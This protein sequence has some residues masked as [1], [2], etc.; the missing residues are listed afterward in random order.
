MRR[1]RS[2]LRRSGRA[3]QSLAEFTMVVPVVIGLFV[4]LIEF[5]Q[6]WHSYQ[7]VTHAARE[8]VRMSIVPGSDPEEVREAVR[9]ILV[10]S[11]LKAEHAEIIVN[12]QSLSGTA[13]TLIIRYPHGFPMLGPV[14]GMIQ[15]SKEMPG[16]VL[17]TSS[18]IMR[19][20]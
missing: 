1:L 16:S 11:N 5:G 2:A 4:A 18:A 8:G 19:N 9:V 13:D 15:K 7:V 17:L 14:V 12:S 20:E 6:A 3:G 10:K